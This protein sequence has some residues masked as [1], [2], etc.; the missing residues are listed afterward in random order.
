M[1]D[2]SRLPPAIEQR[3]APPPRA[4]KLRP[5]AQRVSRVPPPPPPPS[6][7]SMPGAPP[8]AR[9][10]DWDRVLG[11]LRPARAAGDARPVAAHETSHAPARAVQATV[12]PVAPP[13]QRWWR[14]PIVAGAL[15]FALGVVFWHF[16][17]FWSFVGAVVFKPEAGTSTYAARPSGA[18]DDT[19]VRIGGKP[20][21]T[22]HGGLPSGSLPS[23][24]V[25][26]ATLRRDR[27]TGHTTFEPCPQA[28]PGT[29]IA[30]E[31]K[32]GSVQPVARRSDLDAGAGGTAPAVA[33]WSA[34]RDAARP[35]ARS[36][37]DAI[38]ETS[39]DRSFNP[40]R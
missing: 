17:G 38:R 21:T 32:V 33:G 18:G 27:A 15:G 14:R 10:S 24:S 9:P 20:A 4:G 5:L 23:Q 13:P 37:G 11:G 40:R 30:R 26:C 19:V 29:E 3:T 7:T 36:A 39:D 16:V 31:A 22:L 1:T 6:L 25:K 35:Q 28:T 2:P 8:S 12:V 34:T